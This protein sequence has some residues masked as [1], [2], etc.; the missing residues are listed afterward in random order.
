MFKKDD[1]VLIVYKN[2]KRY[3]RRLDPKGSLNIKKEILKF[4][5]IIGKEEGFTK[6]N[7]TV[8][9]PTIEDMILYG[10]RRKT[11]IIYPKDTFFI[12]FKL[13]IKNGSKVVEFGTGSGCTTAVL[14]RLAGKEGKVISF[15]SSEE[16]YKNAMRN[17]REFGLLENVELRNEDFANADLEEGIFDACFVDVKEPWLYTDKVYRIL[18]K[19]GS[20]GF[21]LPTANQ[22]SELLRRLENFGDIQILEIMIRYYKTNPERLRPEDTMVGHTGYLLFGRKL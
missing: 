16:F 8:L 7:F 14:S 2:E 18:R 15:E 10:F 12:A 20:A 1:W 13:D 6:G 5:E 4:K 17:L 9:K 19:G 11:Q 21:L 3:L 22:V